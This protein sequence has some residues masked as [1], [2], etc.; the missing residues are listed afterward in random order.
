MLVVEISG[1]SV[2]TVQLVVTLQQLV[3]FQTPPPTAPMYA[4]ME[5]SLVVVGSMAMVLTASFRRRVIKAP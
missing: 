4:T 5:P 2:V 1:S 3:V